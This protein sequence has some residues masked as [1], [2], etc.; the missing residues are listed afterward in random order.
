MD[1]C[2]SES[3]HRGRPFAGVGDFRRIRP[4]GFSNWQIG[5][6]AALAPE[7]K[8][9]LSCDPRS[10][11]DATMFDENPYTPYKRLDLL[12]N[13]SIRIRCQRERYARKRGAH[14]SRVW[15]PASRRTQDF[16]SP[17]RRSDVFDGTSKTAREDACAPRRVATI[18][19]QQA[20]RSTSLLLRRPVA[21]APLWLKWSFRSIYESSR[22]RYEERI[23]AEV[24]SHSSRK[25]SM[26]RE[27]G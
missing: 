20:C 26:C 16:S 23:K 9:K 13:V 5:C 24:E 17:T 19:D 15:C 21:G 1:G 11:L 14:P 8:A 18:N 3:A 12:P 4:G 22:T 6:T 27:S 2:T 25:K 10:H 7:S